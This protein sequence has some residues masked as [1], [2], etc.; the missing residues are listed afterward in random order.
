MALVIE[1]KFAIV[2]LEVTSVFFFLA[3]GPQAAKLGSKNV[4]N[5]QEIGSHSGHYCAAVT[6]LW[7][8]YI[9]V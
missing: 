1:I 7:F 5:I 3:F 4:S 6:S 2:V 9:I 8:L